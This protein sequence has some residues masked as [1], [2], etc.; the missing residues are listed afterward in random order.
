MAN[1]MRGK[2]ETFARACQAVGITQVLEALPK[3]RVLMVLS[4]HRIGNPEETPYDPGMF[5]CTADEFDWQIRYLKNRYQI[6]TLEQ[7]P[8]LLSGETLLSEPAVLITFDDGYVD[9]YTCALPVLRHHSVQAV[10]FLP[11]AFLG[12][13]RLPWWDV[14]AYIVKRSRRTQITLDYPEP[15]VFHLD[16]DGLNDCIRR[17]LHLY[18][19][20]SMQDH[21]RFIAQLEDAC[22]T[23]S[24]QTLNE[25]S[26][27][28]WDEAREMQRNGMAFGSHTHTHEILGKLSSDRQR[29]ELSI[30]KEILESELRQ[31]IDT[32]AYPVGARTAFSEITMDL[33]RETGYAAAFSHYGG[34]NKPG[35]IQPFD[36]CRCKIGGQSSARLRLQTALGSLTGSY[37]F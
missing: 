30:S 3:R 21:G 37:W 6:I 33:L 36:I 25:R 35:K 31:K 8:G 7:L 26:F 2:R 20:P 24:P 17:I 11:T 5:S 4:Y 22:E 16:L 23:S 34:F 9:N 27:L 12:T 15:G 10:F 32:L 1:S 13:G 18:K 14:I 29:E 28:S 19:K